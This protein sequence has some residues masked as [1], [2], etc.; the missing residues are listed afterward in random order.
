LATTTVMATFC[1]RACAWMASSSA[2]RIS[3]SRSKLTPMRSREG[4]PDGLSP[5][6]PDPQPATS[7]AAISGANARAKRPGPVTSALYDVVAR[8]G[9]RA[10]PG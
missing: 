2:R 3:L 8:C 7:D 6:P 1:R 9:R 5:V 10:E 4:C